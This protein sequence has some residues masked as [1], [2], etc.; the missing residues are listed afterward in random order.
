MAKALGYGMEGGVQ[1]VPLDEVG[2]LV[3]H[4]LRKGHESKPMRRGIFGLS[5][6]DT[7]DIQS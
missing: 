1:P 7:G 2:R 4:R 5:R 6:D 3:G